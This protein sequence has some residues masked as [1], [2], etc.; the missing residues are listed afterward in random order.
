MDRQAAFGWFF[1]GMHLVQQC[2]EQGEDYPNYD[3]SLK[4]FKEEWEANE[5][6]LDAAN[7]LLGEE[8]ENV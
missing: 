1:R 3:K 5:K 2:Y 4:A 6:F 7:E 8:D